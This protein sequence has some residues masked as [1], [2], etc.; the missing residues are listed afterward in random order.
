MT[1]AIQT[2]TGSPKNEPPPIKVNEVL[3][4]LIGNPLVYSIVNP[5]AMVSMASVATN[6]GTLNFVITKPLKK[7]SMAPTTMPAKMAPKT[8]K[9]TNKFMP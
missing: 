2:G 7:P 8:V 5:L 4:E 3:N 1:A 6:G 9:P